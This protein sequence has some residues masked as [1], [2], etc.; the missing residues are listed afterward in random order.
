MLTRKK[1]VDYQ[2]IDL[3]DE[4]PESSPLKQSR[5]RRSDESA[6]DL[7]FAAAGESDG[8]DDS[9]VGKVDPREL[10]PP[11]ERSRGSIATSTPPKGTVQSSLS[12]TPKKVGY[13]KPKATATEKSASNITPPT[14]GKTATKQQGSVK[15]SSV[16]MKVPTNPP[17]KLKA[18]I[19][20]NKTVGS[21]NSEAVKAQEHP[22]KK[23]SGSEIKQAT[24]TKPAAVKKGDSTSS[25]VLQQDNDMKKPPIGKD[26][27]VLQQKKQEVTAVNQPVPSK[28]SE[29]KNT[30]LGSTKTTNIAK[31]VPNSS[32][33]QISQAYPA[34][35]KAKV[36]PEP[37]VKA[38]SA[39]IK[40]VAPK[41][42]KVLQ[43]SM[44]LA[45]ATD[46]SHCPTKF[47]TPTSATL[48]ALNSLNSYTS[49][50]KA[51]ALSL[52]TLTDDETLETALQIA[53]HNEQTT[54]TTLQITVRN[55]A[56]RCK[57]DPLNLPHLFSEVQTQSTLPE[58]SSQ[59]P[60]SALE[61]RECTKMQVVNHPEPQESRCTRMEVD[62]DRG[63]T[64]PDISKKDLDNESEMREPLPRL[65]QFSLVSEMEDLAVRIHPS[66][67][68]ISANA[69]TT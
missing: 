62:L 35:R 48:N 16:L 39:V 10:E 2:K 26:T 24:A 9:D 22:E 37:A 63:M 65:L 21:K 25:H 40:P 27:K 23:K 11:Q 57:K 58:A 43:A 51:V 17:S 1:T 60:I 36:I 67:S 49:S 44:I 53:N 31:I 56:V 30:N 38:A 69:A 28:P 64:E 18:P 47:D 32:N 66:H 13:V 3:D 54:D 68:A 12:T 50:F 55:S 15:K 33:K 6:S 7:D 59:S 14:S 34:S 20:S 52:E 4:M 5:K 8:D 46:R 19:S 29:A 42:D 61:D 41:I 45:S